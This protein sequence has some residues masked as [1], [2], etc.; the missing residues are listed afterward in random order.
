MRD[1]RGWHFHGHDIDRHGRI[2]QL[3]THLLSRRGHPPGPF[4]YECMMD[5]MADPQGSV[6]GIRKLLDEMQAQNMTP[7]ATLCRSALAALANHPDYHLR[8]EMLNTMHDFWFTVDAPVRQSVLLGLLRDEQYELAYL[9][10][11]EMAEQDAPVDLWV[12]DIFIMVFGKLRFIDEMM[13]LLHQRSKAGNRDR[14]R[15]RGGGGGGGGDGDGDGAINSVLY[16]ALDVCSQAFHYPGTLFAWNSMVRSSLFQPSD[17]IVE[18]VL[19]TAARH[20]D[21]SLATE[22]LDMLSR[23]TR[24]LAHH[25]E[26]VA[27]AFAATG[28]VAGAFRILCIMKHNG[29]RIGRASTTAVSDVLRRRPELIPEAEEALRGMAVADHELPAAAVGAVVEAIAQ[30]RGSR[31]A[32]A[33]YQD[34][35]KLCGEPAD[36][37]VVRTLMVHSDDAEATRSL[38]RDYLRRA[39]DGAD[40]NDGAAVHSSHAYRALVAACAEA[41]ELDLAFGFA[42]RAATRHSGGPAEQDVEW[43]KGLVAKAVDKEDGR[44]WGVVDELSKDDRTGAAVEKMLRQ[45][46]LTRRAADMKLRR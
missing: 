3:V 26:A 9:R 13:L 14:D 42:D 28:D 40:D 35:P 31:A 7:T 36:P 27:E 15:D 17:G 46:R 30:S 6:R 5:A 37:V 12:Y 16:Y 43:V 32:M 44:I 33:L 19:A 39:P 10:L 23:R 11:T 24:V 45:M 1:P 18:N 38:A 41:D 29:I 8:Q 2:V 34:M 22:A 4:V 21:A 20:G 25:Y